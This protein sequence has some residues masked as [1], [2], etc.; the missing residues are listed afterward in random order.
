MAAREQQQQQQ[1][2]PPQL[3]RERPS[4]SGARPSPTKRRHRPFGGKGCFSSSSSSPLSLC[5]WRP[6]A[7]TELLLLLWPSL[8][9]KQQA[10]TRASAAASGL[11]A[12]TPLFSFSF[13]FGDAN[14]IM[15]GGDAGTTAASL[16]PPVDFLA[17]NSTRPR[18]VACEILIVVFVRGTWSIWCG[19]GVKFVPHRSKSTKERTEFS[20][21]ISSLFSPSVCFLF[22]FSP[23][24]SGMSALVGRLP[25][26]STNARD[27]DRSESLSAAAIVFEFFSSFLFLNFFAE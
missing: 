4:S 14:A 15:V 2:E 22:L 27:H 8:E 17:L 20:S 11:A 13:S 12:T 1:Q 24:S 19:W 7:A 6:G 21:L 18:T 5:W 23:T 3:S 25:C 9:E 16:L 26:V 10:A